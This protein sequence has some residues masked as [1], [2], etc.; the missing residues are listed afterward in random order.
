MTE[1]EQLL[2]TAADL[3]E[4]AELAKKFERPVEMPAEVV[5]V[6][7]YF[8]ETCGRVVARAGSI[9]ETGAREG[10]IE[11]AHDLART[12]LGDIK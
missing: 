4:Q 8:I 1:A 12:H 6:L 9:K 5:H 10:R 7:A 11:H 3:M 2:I